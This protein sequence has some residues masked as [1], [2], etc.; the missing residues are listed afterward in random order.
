MEKMRQWS[1]LT[2]LGVVGVLVAGWFLLVSPQRSHAKDLKAQVTTQQASTNS[3]EAQ[4]Q[5]LKQ[6][7]KDEPAQQRKLMK[8][9]TQIPDNPALPALIRTLSSA[10]H[11]AG[12]TLVSL[13]PAP[14]A[15]VTV[16]APAVATPTTGA[17]ATAVTSSL[18]QISLTVQVVGSYFNVESFFRS[19]EHLDRAM[20][21]T[22]FTIAPGSVSS[23]T[24]TNTSTGASTGG[25]TDAAT[26][27]PGTL[28]AQIQAVVFESPE[29][30]PA[31]GVSPVTPTTPSTQAPATA[32][33]TAPSAGSAQ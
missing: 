23:G 2:V 3:L 7:Q 26:A 28:N 27:A 32:A 10:A 20:L 16:A 11:D 8:I 22:G 24:S 14:P 13:A 21:V 6:Q 1:L 33:T 25:S 29:V 15:A 19:V 30:A 5:Q 4:V 9:A 31:T 12:V 18:A 17:A